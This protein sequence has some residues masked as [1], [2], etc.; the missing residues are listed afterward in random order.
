VLVSSI[1][2]A[3]IG[4]AG[5]LLWFISARIEL[6]KDVAVGSGWSSDLVASQHKARESMSDTGRAGWHDE[7]SV[8]L[9]AVRFLR[10]LGMAMTL[11]GAAC[12]MLF[13]LLQ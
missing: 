3:L 9:E 1:G 13:E 6:E 12:L 10:H 8:A 4:L 7:Q 11:I 5:L 2:F